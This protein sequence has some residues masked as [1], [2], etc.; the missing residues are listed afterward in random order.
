MD[1]QHDRK[2]ILLFAYGNLSRGDD[3]LGPMLLQRIEHIYR[4]RHC[5]HPLIFLQDYQ[6][7][8]EHVMDM[9]GCEQVVLIDAAR[10]LLEPVQFYPVE[11]RADISHHSTHV[12]SPSRLLYVY[13]QVHGESAPSTSMLAIQG[14]SFELGDP[15]SA[16][17]ERNLV[18]AE[19][20][21]VELLQC[22]DIT[23]WE[24]I[25]QQKL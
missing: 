5:C 16:T 14:S 3:A 25:T 12:I 24:D 22:D 15:L 7:Q 4:H 2:P 1:S 10:N 20:F 19:A 18:M 23:D 9:H 11:E 8:I 17:A 21:L 6:I 13:R